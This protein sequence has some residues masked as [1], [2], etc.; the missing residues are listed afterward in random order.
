M[1]KIRTHFSKQKKTEHCKSSKE[2]I[3]FVIFRSSEI[4][5]NQ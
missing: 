3:F 5:N 4:T 1:I 2:A